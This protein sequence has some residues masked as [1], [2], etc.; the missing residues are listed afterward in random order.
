MDMAPK[1]ANKVMMH[2]VE[3]TTTTQRKYND[4]TPE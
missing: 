3:N 1:V 2:Y 4:H